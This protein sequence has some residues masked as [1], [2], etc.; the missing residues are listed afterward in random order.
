MTA[1]STSPCAAVVARLFA[2]A[3]AS[4]EPLAVQRRAL[5]EDQLDALMNGS[6]HKGLYGA[7]KEFHLAVSPDTAM[8]LYM[9]ARSI[10][11]RSIVEFGTSCGVSA[12]HLAAALRDNGGG[13]LIGTEFEPGKLEQA[14]ANLRAAGLSDLAE[15]RAGDALETL[16]VDLPETLDLV[17]LDGAKSLYL[18]VLLQLEPRLRCGAVILADN[19]HW[20]PQYLARVRD[21]ASGY[22]SVPI[23]NDV[24]FTVRA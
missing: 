6:D 7:L 5:P 21:A 20:A 12:V 16:R 1:L 24:E 17:S 4:D 13:R 2:E 11:A 19:A 22:F 8:L 9:L 23:A 3:Q 14:C 10:R 15:I 18:Q